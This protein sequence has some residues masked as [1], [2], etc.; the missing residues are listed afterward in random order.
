MFQ[1]GVIMDSRHSCCMFAA[2]LQEWRESKLVPV[3]T[4]RGP[5]SCALSMLR[6]EKWRYFDCTLNTKS[7]RIRGNSTRGKIFVLLQ[8]FTF[9]A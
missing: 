2:R 6:A 9:N 7:S 3:S 5:V 4:D 8:L 1:T